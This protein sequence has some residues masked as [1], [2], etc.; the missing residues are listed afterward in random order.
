VKDRYQV[1]VIGGGVVG[2]SVLYHLALRGCTD[3][4]LHRA[5]PSTQHINVDL[6]AQCGAGC[7]GR[8]TAT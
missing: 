3:T 7:S 2:C 8:R 4:A 6:Y 5:P 1:V